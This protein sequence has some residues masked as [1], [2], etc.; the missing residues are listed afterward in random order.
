MANDTGKTVL[1]TK[2]RTQVGWR[3]EDTDL[4]KGRKGD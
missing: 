4:A 2:Q 3:V 1:E